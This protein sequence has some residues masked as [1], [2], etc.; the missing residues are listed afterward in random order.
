MEG[1]R[2]EL[3]AAFVEDLRGIDTRI[4]ETRMQLAVAASGTS[5]TGGTVSASSSPPS[6]SATSA[7]CPAF[8][9]ATTSPPMTGPRRS[10]CPLARANLP[11]VPARSRRLNHA[12]HMV[13]VTQIGHRHSQG[14]YDKMLA[15]GKTPNPPGQHG[16]EVRSRAGR[17]GAL[18]TRYD[19]SERA[20]GFFRFFAT[21]APGFPGQAESVVAAGLAAGEDP[22]EAVRAAL[23]LHASEIAFWDALADGLRDG[24]R[25]P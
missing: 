5:L 19:L 3:A 23:A 10:R 11:A 17:G 18:M 2:C 7:T 21:P 15:E 9:A 14:R 8:P 20:A 22:Q 1:A 25:G 12:I 16:R 4:R 24:P 13:A 6:S